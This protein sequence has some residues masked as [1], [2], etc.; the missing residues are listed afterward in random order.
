MNS[1]TNMI[2]DIK[3]EIIVEGVETKEQESQAKSLHCEM[4]QGYLYSKPLE[5]EDFLKFMNA[6][7]RTVFLILTTLTLYLSETES[8]LR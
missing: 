5:V 3:A 2:H 1:I 6:H 7:I 8:V 4:G